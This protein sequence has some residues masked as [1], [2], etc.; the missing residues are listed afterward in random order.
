MLVDLV[1][2]FSRW[3][4]LKGLKI[5]RRR[6]TSIYEKKKKGRT[7]DLVAFAIQHVV[8]VLANTDPSLQEAFVGFSVDKQRGRALASGRGQLKELNKKKKGRQTK[9]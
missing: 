3:S 8:G 6:E 9:M 7:N 4:I 2:K 1:G 5:H